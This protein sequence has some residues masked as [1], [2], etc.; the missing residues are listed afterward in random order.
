[1]LV[2]H[3]EE[4]SSALAQWGAD[5][6]NASSVVYAAVVAS[7]DACPQATSDREYAWEGARAHSWTITV[8]GQETQHLWVARTDNAVGFLWTGGSAGHVPED[9][10]QRV[11]SALVAGLLSSKSFH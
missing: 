5:Q 7:V 6:P 4:S 1:M 9:V 3:D 10:D 8:G 2:S 11:A